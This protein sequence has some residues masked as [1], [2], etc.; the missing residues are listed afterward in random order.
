MAVQSAYN[1]AQIDSSVKKGKQDIYW[2]DFDFNVSSLLV[3][4]ATSKPDYDQVEN[5]YLFSD[6]STESVIGSKISRHEFKLQA[7]E[8]RPHVH[9]A[10]SNSGDVVW[11]LEYKIW[12]ASS[13]E[14]SWVTI[15]TT[16]TEFTYTSGVIHQ[17]STFPP[18][19]MSAYDSTAM[20]VKVRISRLGADASDTY[21]GD[22]RFMGF[23]FHVPI[24]RFGS[25]Q[26]YV[27]ES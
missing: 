18:I 7:D 10:Q 24:D 11:Q 19:V 8:W 17:I 6:S 5:E 14:P 3:N 1:I 2:D 15:T 26:E 27:K 20:E 22:A 16:A 23:D 13:V 25:E 21:T 12:P 4:P 9:W